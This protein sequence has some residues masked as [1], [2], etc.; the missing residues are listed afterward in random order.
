MRI[1]LILIFLF[2]QNTLAETNYPTSSWLKKDVAKMIER[3]KFVTK[4]CLN[5]N[6]LNLPEVKIIS[7][8]KLISEN[9]NA[10]KRTV[11]H[12]GFA[13]LFNLTW[14]VSDLMLPIYSIAKDPAAILLYR[15]AEKAQKLPKLQKMTYLQRA[16]IA[17][18]ISANITD[19]YPDTFNTQKSIKAIPDNIINGVTPVTI[20]ISRGTSE[21]KE[22]ARIYNFYASRLGVSSVI[23]MGS[24]HVFNAVI[25][26]KG[27]FILEPQSDECA[28]AK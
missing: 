20:A 14:G 22:F 12:N 24:E 6:D 2:S 10:Y 27:T 3:E 16:C 4:K 28:F 11:I 7:I 8:E 5:E 21:C 19:Y 9:G 25:T 17:K 15:L 26:D 13:M 23:A 18:C 1:F